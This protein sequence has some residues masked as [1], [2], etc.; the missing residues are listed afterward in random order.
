MRQARAL[1]VRICRKLNRHPSL[2][3]LRGSV[4]TYLAGTMYFV[5]EM[6]QES[7][8]R[9]GESRLAVLLSYML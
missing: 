8:G 1:P 5:P 4:D 3:A 6:R 9:D 2:L 7:G